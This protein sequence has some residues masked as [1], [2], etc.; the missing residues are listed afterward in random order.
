M[1]ALGK[2][3]MR[4][5]GIDFGERRVGIAAADDRTR[6]AVPVRTLTVEGDPVEAIVRAVQEEGAAELVVGLPLTLAGEEGPQAQRVRQAAEALS[7][8]L[9]IPVRMWDER[10]TTVQAGRRLSPKA[11]RPFGKAQG[12]LRRGQPPLARARPSTGSGRAGRRVPFERP[13]GRLRR[14]QDEWGR[15]AAAAAILLQAYLDSRRG[16]V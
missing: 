15:D 6:V 14:A 4:I 3:G 11:L 5:I 13:Q 10:L 2:D 9:G 7:A 8:R 12:G 16:D 1:A